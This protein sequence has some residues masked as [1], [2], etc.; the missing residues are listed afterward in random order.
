MFAL[1]TGGGGPVY[2]QLKDRILELM[3]LEVLRPGDSLPTVRVMAR[4]MGV[5]P[6]S[7]AR[8]YRELEQ[9]GVLSHDRPS[10]AVWMEDG[11]VISGSHAA[12]EAVQTQ[13]L[14]RLERQ[15]Q[16]ARG[17]GVSCGQ[18]AGLVRQIFEGEAAT[19]P[20]E[21]ANLP[22]N[23]GAA[24]FLSEERGVNPEKKGGEL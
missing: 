16:E 5:S 18:I 11:A 21:G 22:E 19:G 24:A 2:L 8:A 3:G 23:R 1:D 10:G 4:E 7:V 13:C 6:R 14:R 17:C 9:E 20:D 12:R 15:I